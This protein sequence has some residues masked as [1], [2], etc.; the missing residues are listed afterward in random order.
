MIDLSDG[1]ATDAGHLGRSSNVS[2]VIE[3]EELPLEAGV[4]E[5]CAELAVPAWQLA[6]GGGE[7]YELCFCAP[8]QARERVERA[9]PASAGVGISWIGE[10][11]SGEPGVSLLADGQDVRLSGYEHRW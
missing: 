2:L 4:R 9:V 8:L 5:I 7:D 1:L 11:V 10:V 3:L 6:A